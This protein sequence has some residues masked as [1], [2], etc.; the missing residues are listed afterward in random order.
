MKNNI[1]INYWRYIVGFLLILLPSVLANIPYLNL[2]VLET[3]QRLVYF[4]VAALLIF[5]PKI[6]II[7]MFILILLCFHLVSLLLHQDVGSNV[8]GLVMY[9]SIIYIWFKL[10]SSTKKNLK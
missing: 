7:V 9:T 6:R 8:L 1:L 2:L 4:W 5:S 3:D 10:M